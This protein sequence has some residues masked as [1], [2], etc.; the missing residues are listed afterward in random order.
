[1]SLMMKLGEATALLVVLVTVI[2]VGAA[3]MIFSGFPRDEARHKSVQAV[4]GL[5]ISRTSK[6]DE[7]RAVTLFLL[8][9]YGNNA[10]MVR[11]GTQRR[12]SQSSP[13]CGRDR[14]SDR[15]SWTVL[16]RQRHRPS[17]DIPR[18]DKKGEYP[19]EPGET[20]REPW[21]GR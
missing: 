5:R 9:R 13:P 12:S 14:P 7:T 20:S 3:V 11:P 19:G 10:E 6:K 18:A 16:G 2:T 1:M 4:H 8:V 17:H 21:L 15:P